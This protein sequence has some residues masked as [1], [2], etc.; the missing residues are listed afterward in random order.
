MI[1]RS[2]RR[3][4]AGAILTLGGEGVAVSLGAD[5]MVIAFK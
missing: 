5:A 3:L 2:R 1:D 4:L